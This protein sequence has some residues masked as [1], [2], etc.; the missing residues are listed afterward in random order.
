M[1]KLF[2]TICILTMASTVY[3]DPQVIFEWSANTEANLVG[4]RL[5][6]SDISGVY[7]YGGISSSNFIDVI[8]C[9]PNQIECCT[10]TAPYLQNSYY[11]LTAFDSDGDESGPSNEVHTISPAKPKDFKR[12]K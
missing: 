3:A 1:K 5:Y 4:Y 6:R 9:G 2:L 11:V 7:N 10:Y 12:V 8:I